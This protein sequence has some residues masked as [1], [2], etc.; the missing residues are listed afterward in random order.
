MGFRVG[1]APD[2]WVRSRRVQSVMVACCRSQS[3]FAGA[4][5]RRALWTWIAFLA[6]LFM[7]LSLCPFCN[8]TI[9]C[10]LRRRTC[11][12]PTDTALAAG[13]AA[14]W[15]TRRPTM[16]QMGRGPVLYCTG[17]ERWTFSI[18]KGRNAAKNARLRHERRNTVPRERQSAMRPGEWP[19]GC[20]RQVS[21]RGPRHPVVKETESR[22]A[23]REK[24]YAHRA[25]SVFDCTWRCAVRGPEPPASATPSSSQ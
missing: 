20:A 17:P 4:V 5:C 10:C 12:G 8:E 13:C 19:G 16:T 14:G 6:S 22:I 2:P 25:G 21:T 1:G 15:A 3:E 24:R 11:P 9:F 18:H 7:P 23:K